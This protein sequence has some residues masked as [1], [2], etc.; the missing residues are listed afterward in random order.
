MVE[1]SFVN[2]YHMGWGRE[3]KGGGG[4]VGG[5]KIG[6][7]MVFK[8]NRPGNGP[9]HGFP[10]RLLQKKKGFKTFSVSDYGISRHSRARIGFLG[11]DY[12]NCRAS[13]SKIGFG[14]V[15]SQHPYYYS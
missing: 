7:R 11:D 8:G 3:G 14:T 1:A 4:G 5:R 13:D 15:G 10:K 12:A 2:I 9:C 6:D